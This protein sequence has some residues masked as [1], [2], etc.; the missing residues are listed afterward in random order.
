MMRVSGPSRFFLWSPGVQTD[1]GADQN[2]EIGG[3][4][5]V[6]CLVV[7][8]MGIAEA[9]DPVVRYH[10]ARDLERESRYAQSA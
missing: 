4:Q 9:T 6:K 3:F 10:S 1:F 7:L 2:N 5:L 8:G